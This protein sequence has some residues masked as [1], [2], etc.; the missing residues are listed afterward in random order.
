M[1]KDNMLDIGKFE[2]KSIRKETHWKSKI[3]MFVM[4]EKIWEIVEAPK[5]G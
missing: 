3:L 4:K 2:F 1:S 5:S